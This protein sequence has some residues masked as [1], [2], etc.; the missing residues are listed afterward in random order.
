MKQKKKKEENS[1]HH[2]KNPQNTKAGNAG[3]VHL[4][5]ICERVDISDLHEW[6][7]LQML[8]FLI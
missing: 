6:K 4:L 2:P 3:Y 8:S 7:D 5:F 1:H